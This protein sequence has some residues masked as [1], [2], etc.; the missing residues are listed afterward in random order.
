MPAAAL[1]YAGLDGARMLV[2]QALAQ[3]EI[4][5]GETASSRDLERSLTRLREARD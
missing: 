4:F 2:V 1:G 3:F 5:T